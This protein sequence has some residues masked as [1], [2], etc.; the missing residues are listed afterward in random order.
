MKRTKKFDLAPHTLSVNASSLDQA[1]NIPL[2]IEFHSQ[3]SRSA[4]DYLIHSFVEDSTRRK[5][6]P[7]NAGWRT[8]M[9]VVK[10]TRVT[11]YS[12][13]ESS[14]SKGKPLSELEPTGTG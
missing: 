2:V 9:D 14:R 6:P 4:F 13:Y 1:E 10:N 8:L 12:L 3:A 5:V 7:E 11:K